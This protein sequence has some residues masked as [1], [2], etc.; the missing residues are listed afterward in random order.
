MGRDTAPG[1]VYLQCS[2]ESDGLFYPFSRYPKSLSVGSRCSI[3]VVP[4]GFL[5]DDRYRL[6]HCKTTPTTIGPAKQVRVHIHLVAATEEHWKFC[7]EHMTHLSKTENRFLWRSSSDARTLN[8]AYAYNLLFLLVLLP[9]MFDSKQLLRLSKPQPHS[10]S[11]TIAQ[12]LF[13]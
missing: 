11:T 8:L 4:I 2:Q 12:Y 13:I 3:A 9:S 5:A 7:D 6:Y 1:S 10:S